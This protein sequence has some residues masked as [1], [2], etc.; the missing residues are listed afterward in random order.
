MYLTEHDMRLAFWDS[1]EAP[2][3][4]VERLRAVYPNGCSLAEALALAGPFDPRHL[5]CRATYPAL[6][7][8]LD[9]GN[10]LRPDGTLWVVE[11][12]RPVPELVIALAPLTEHIGALGRVIVYIPAVRL[13]DEPP[14]PFEEPADAQTVRLWRG[15]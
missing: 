5:K 10:V 12:R 9:A 7:R 4:A 15:K 11:L 3:A 1:P 14:F 8:L 6:R 2:P 13:Q